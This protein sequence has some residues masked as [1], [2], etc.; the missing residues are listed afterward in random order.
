[1][2][3]TLDSPPVAFANPAINPPRLGSPVR[4]GYHSR[5]QS[6][7]PVRQYGQARDLDPILRNLSPTT[8][9]RAFSNG[10]EAQGGSLAQAYESSTESQ[11]GLGVK[12]AQACLD[13]RS[14]TREL[15]AWEWPGTFEAPSQAQ[16]R[17]KQGDMSMK[18]PATS[19]NGPVHENGGAEQ[20]YWGSLP[21]STVQRY[22]QRVDQV[23]QELD[24]IDVEQLKEFVLSAHHEAGIGSASVDDSIGAIGAATDLRKLDDFTAIITATILQALPYLSRL[25]CLLDV[26][27]LRVAVL[28]QAP[29][30]L[31]ALVQAQQ[32][33][34]NGWAALAKSPTENNGLPPAAKLTQE[35]LVEIQGATERG[36]TDVGRTLDGFLDDL[37]GREETV[38][39]AWI[40]DLENLEQQYADWT[41]QAQ[42]RVLE[43][44][45]NALRARFEAS[46]AERTGEPQSNGTLMPLAV[47]GSTSR[48]VSRDGSHVSSLD[49]DL[50]TQIS[51]D[52]GIRT[53]SPIESRRVSPQRSS[54]VEQ[55]SDDL[56]REE[57][58]AGITD[59]ADPIVDDNKSLAPTTASSHSQYSRRHVPIIL[60][61]SEGDGQEY[62]SQGI[63]GDISSRA[64][65]PASDAVISPPPQTDE[66][67]PASI[68]KKRTA[69]LGGLERN[70]SLQRNAKS[71]VR[72][73]EHASNAFTR[74]FRKAEQQQSN[75]KST[76]V[77]SRRSSL[78]SN[79][80][81]KRSGSGKSE[82][83]IIWGGRPDLKPPTT[84]NN[85]TASRRSS[86]RNRATSLESTPEDSPV[87]AA[88]D[89][90]PLPAM[91]L[92]HERW[93][94]HGSA[95]SSARNSAR[96]SLEVPETY[97]P[98][99]LLPPF[100]A[101]NEGVVAE[102]PTAEP[103]SMLHFG[104]NWP[105]VSPEPSP[106]DRPSALQP[107][108]DER[109][110]EAEAEAES[111]GPEIES[112]KKPLQSDSFD[113]MFLDSLPA[114]PS[115][116][117]RSPVRSGN[118]LSRAGSRQRERTSSHL[119][120]TSGMS[121][122]TVKDFMLEETAE[123]AEESKKHTINPGFKFED[124]P[125]SAAASREGDEGA[126]ED[127]GVIHATSE[128]RSMH[129]DLPTYEALEPPQEENAAAGAT[130]SS[131]VSNLSSPGEIRDA[132]IG[133]FG[134]PTL[135]RTSTAVN[136]SPA[137]RTLSG[138]SPLRLDIPQAQT[139]D[140]KEPVN[141]IRERPS[142]ID[143]ASMASIEAHPRESVKSI[144][145]RRS[146]T[147]SMLDSN[148]TSPVDAATSPVSRRDVVMFPSPPNGRS[149]QPMSPVSPLEEESPNLERTVSPPTPQEA[150]VPAFR[151]VQDSP[152]HDKGE[153]NNFMG[154]RRGG[155]VEPAR[156]PASKDG[157]KVR[158]P[159]GDSFDRHISEVLE[160]LPAPIRFRS[161]AQT[162]LGVRTAEPRSYSGPRPKNMRVPS[163]PSGGLTLAPA[164]PTPSKKSH[165]ASEPEVKLYH[166]TQAGREDP[167]KLF[168]RLVGENERVMVR[169]GGGWADLADYLRQYAEHHGS[170]TVSEGTI[171][172]QTV[173]TAG[174]PQTL[175]RRV[176]GP[177][178]S[179]AKAT[180]TPVTPA[181]A[182][183]RPG[184]K[185]SNKSVP[186]G[187]WISGPQG[188][189]SMG[190]PSPGELSSTPALDQAV[191]S[192]PPPTT[193]SKSSRPST[194]DASSRPGSRHA[195]S[196]EGGLGGSG[197]KTELPE[198][199]AKWVEGMLEKVTKASA[200]KSKEDKS[201][202]FG[203]LGKVGGT[204]RVVFRSSSAQQEAGAK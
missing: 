156:R 109:G 131:M 17:Q 179:E 41:V 175:N 9:L 51:P 151:P 84:K 54:D 26:W 137:R 152:T 182:G 116:T 49:H 64:L 6:H 86:M 119:R 48:D 125:K 178:N 176:S 108:S 124:S 188:Q 98:T 199:K 97:Q 111:S 39:D 11:R 14:W 23:A 72:P 122:P 62:P 135:S 144:D 44:E 195:W 202:A 105:L 159:E 192:S 177:L 65:S 115:D 117:P 85:S 30:F 173:A 35:S 166:L 186:P 57:F 53:V 162:P 132:S 204:R 40:E 27:T 172:V 88:A 185:D 8:T 56:A 134:S 43:D 31:Q 89:A 180:R 187:D 145:V 201:R 63:T 32:N 82:D 110:V 47:D 19:H 153:L 20:E 80:G 4:R 10:Y 163:R 94:N 42:R 76:P 81:R 169:V 197:K 5:T 154:K 28:R 133:Y 106:E 101:A 33:L 92:R 102:E 171:D 78:R 50:L 200:E 114:S 46:A 170:R 126:V 90:P 77:S 157:L 1:M 55:P 148:P 203:E 112:P 91:P 140:A 146:S 99:R 150:V 16:K 191:S 25:N 69:F 143:R 2:A 93:S 120:R 24:E 45:L 158:A 164:D 194:A 160:K 68:V 155:P 34:E 74:L 183:A 113:R 75:D 136:E 21:A 193:P 107:A 67:P 167:I 174:T 139:V 123:P 66:A 184:S 70:E 87:K 127:D 147:S 118:P 52:D 60:P 96:T 130:P 165:S 100:E 59:I 141:I 7:S 12:A 142:L 38:P 58:P 36:I 103:K 129:I 83:G 29:I 15:E 138:A 79:E 104:E 149:S 73:F 189:F 37:E 161:G 13:I 3:E 121:V 128:P 181:T 18:I 61:Y 71:P 22:E 196:S 198:H 190:E 95:R 168:V